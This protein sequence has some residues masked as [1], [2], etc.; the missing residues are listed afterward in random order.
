MVDVGLKFGSSA[1][2]PNN[3]IFGVKTNVGQGVFDDGSKSGPMGATDRG[4]NIVIQPV[5][6]SLTLNKEKHTAMRIIDRKNVDSYNDK[7]NKGRPL[8]EI[9]GNHS[10]ASIGLKST[11][12]GLVCDHER[13]PEKTLMKGDSQIVEECIVVEDALNDG[14]V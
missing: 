7:E 9:M 10:H 11:M 5:D 12:E 2:R 4:K 1:L 8:D 14:V 6:I 3:D 13:T